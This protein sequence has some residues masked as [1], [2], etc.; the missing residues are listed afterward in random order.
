MKRNPLVMVMFLAVGLVLGGVI[1]DLLSSMMPILNDT[2]TL[3]VNPFT[4]DLSVLTVTL[5]F[6]INLSLSSVLGL[7]IGM[8]VYSKV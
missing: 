6:S 7:L 5:G 2:K 3:G 8:F 1:G 4:V